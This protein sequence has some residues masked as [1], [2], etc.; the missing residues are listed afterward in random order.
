[1]SDFVMGSRE[2]LQH[3]HSQNRSRTHYNTQ[4]FLDNSSNVVVLP[5]EKASKHSSKDLNSE[6]SND[7]A[8]HYPKGHHPILTGEERCMCER[9]RER[10]SFTERGTEL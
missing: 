9:E 2:R 3:T 5:S 7:H 8:A 4:P 10:D 1:M 6:E